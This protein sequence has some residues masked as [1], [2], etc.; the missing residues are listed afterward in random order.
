M[1]KITKIWGEEHWLANE[2]FCCKKLLVSEGYM[3]S[4]HYHKIKDELFYVVYG[5][6]KIELND[7]IKILKAG[8][9]VRVKPEDKHRF[10]GLEDSLIIESST[11]HIEEDSY[12][13]EASKKIKEG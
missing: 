1:K 6:V 10:S 4:L 8:D 13:I 5:K 7:I 9:W 11:H 2:E 3:C 12:R